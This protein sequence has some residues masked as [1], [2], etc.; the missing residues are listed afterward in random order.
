MTEVAGPEPVRLDARHAI[1]A[2]QLHAANHPLEMLTTIE[3]QTV[4]QVVDEVNLAG[5]LHV[6]SMNVRWVCV[7]ESVALVVEP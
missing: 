6:V 4:Q 3:E 5:N 2:D 7:V 1:T